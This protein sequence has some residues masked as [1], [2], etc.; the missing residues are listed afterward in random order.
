MTFQIECQKALSLYF[1]ARQQWEKELEYGIA[2]SMLNKALTMMRTR[3][4]PTGRGLPEIKAKSP[5]K[6]VEKDLNDVKKHMQKVL[7][8]WEK[9]NS[10]I[11]FDKVP[12]TLPAD[13][14]LTQG[15][16]MMK[17]EPYEL[18]VVEPVALILP[19]GDV[20]DTTAETSEDLDYELAKQL[21][22]QLNAE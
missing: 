13:K 2:I 20:G 10:G 3:D 11:Y 12:L 19:G 21:Q 9:D 14:K 1:H 17:P 5:L 8:A 6:A 7:Q 22:E 16:R 15:V 18:E 4:T